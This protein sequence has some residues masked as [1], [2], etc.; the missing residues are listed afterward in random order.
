MMPQRYGT[1]PMDEV[2]CI[3]SRIS[4]CMAQMQRYADILG[5]LDAT[6]DSPYYVASLR[7]RYWEYM[8]FAD[9][10]RA[11]LDRVCQGGS[12]ALPAVGDKRKLGE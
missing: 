10:L 3:E 4:S 6:N 12:K 1:G 8:A 11:E 5:D 2:V 7:E 9:R